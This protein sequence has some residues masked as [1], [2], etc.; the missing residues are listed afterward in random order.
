MVTDIKCNSPIYDIIH[1]CVVG[2]CVSYVSRVLGPI[3]KVLPS[4]KLDWLPI[5]YDSIEK[6]DNSMYARGV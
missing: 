6:I 3:T 5:T 2:T 4:T 1:P